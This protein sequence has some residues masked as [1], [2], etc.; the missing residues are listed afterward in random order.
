MFEKQT[1]GQRSPSLHEMIPQISSAIDKRFLLRTF[2]VGNKRIKYYHSEPRFQ[3]ALDQASWSLNPT[4]MKLFFVNIKLCEKRQDKM[5]M[6]EGGVTETFDNLEQKTYRTN[7]ETCSCSYFHQM[8]FCRHIVFYRMNTLLPV[9][10]ASIFH[11]SLMKNGD[12]S[13]D[14]PFTNLPDF[15]DISP[16]SPGLEMVMTEEKTRRR[17]PTQ[18]KK[19]NM[20]LDL[21]KE[22]AEVISTY[23]SQTFEEVL[24]TS[25]CYLKEVRKGISKDLADYLKSPGSFLIVPVVPCVQGSSQDLVE[26]ATECFDH[27]DNEENELEDCQYRSQ[28][29]IP[30]T[31]I[32]DTSQNL[33]EEF[34]TRPDSHVKDSLDVDESNLECS[35][36]NHYMSSDQQSV[37]CP[38]ST[39]LESFN[40]RVTEQM[41]LVEDFDQ[42]EFAKLNKEMASVSESTLC[43]EKNNEQSSVL[44]TPTQISTMTSGMMCA[45]IKCMTLRSSVGGLH[46]CSG[47]AGVA[48]CGKQCQDEGWVAHR[49]V[50]KKMKGE[51]WG[52]KV[53]LVTA[54]ISLAMAMEGNNEDHSSQ[55]RLSPASFDYEY[56]DVEDNNENGDDIS[57]NPDVYSTN[58]ATTEIDKCMLPANRMHREKLSKKCF[59]KASESSQCSALPLSADDGLPDIHYTPHANMVD[60]DEPLKFLNIVKK[61]GRPILKRQSTKFKVKTKTMSDEVL[62]FFPLKKTCEDKPK[63][64]KPRADKGKKRGSYKFGNPDNL[65]SDV[66]LRAPRAPK[67]MEALRK[68]YG[69]T[70]RPD[71]CCT[72][73]FSLDFD[74]SENDEEKVVRCRKCKSFIH[75]S[76][77]KNCGFCENGEN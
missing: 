13:E 54:M 42:Q 71:K 40:Y 28:P 43:T 21:G 30:S 75:Q 48:Y 11:A 52:M 65:G 68:E 69:E 8:F 60:D 74:E 22:L 15:E 44:V 56:I 58:P 1:F 70:A 10:D 55:P 51:S 76:C 66:S 14:V 41:E 29:D 61:K 19:F 77:A 62:E 33:S 63:Q 31:L 50:C 18:A 72:C 35:D 26:Q 36:S 38:S 45:N 16:P 37:H 3:T 25:K 17:N 2:L 20:A 47:C 64:R 9:F 23:E 4:G 5:S 57:A 32:S 34:M 24:E 53:K 59:F 12:I 49:V 7:G 67:N 27:L 73:D 39:L 6:A 46:L